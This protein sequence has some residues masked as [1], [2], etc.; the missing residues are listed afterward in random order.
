MEIE[1]A[2]PVHG[3]ILLNENIRVCALTNIECR[4]F[5]RVSPPTV[6][7]A[8]DFGIAQPAPLGALA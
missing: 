5:V 2:P 4:G 1:R 3:A 7:Y 8:Q 6:D